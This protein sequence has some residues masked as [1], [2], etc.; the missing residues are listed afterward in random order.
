[1]N[2]ADAESLCKLACAP[3]NAEETTNIPK[4]DKG[5]ASKEEDESPKNEHVFLSSEL[6]NI[7]LSNNEEGCTSDEREFHHDSFPQRY[8]VSDFTTSSVSHF[9]DEEAT[10]LSYEAAH[11]KSNSSLHKDEPKDESGVEIP[12]KA[13]PLSNRERLLLRKQALKMKKR[14]VLAV[15][16]NNILTGVAKTIKTHF[17]KY[18]L[19]IVNVKGRA[20][21]TSVQEVIFELEQA[22]GSV[23]VS[24][25]PNKVI[26]Y[27]GWGEGEPPGSNLKDARKAS[28]GANEE[29]RVSLKLLEAVSLECGLSTSQLDQDIFD[30]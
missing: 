30:L 9:S 12:F 7:N 10:E 20:E 22:T 8:Q 14:P 13:A 1:M 18:P 2:E 26:L 5:I 21:G 16:R 28:V 19:A 11:S 25:E 6:S 29:G 4:N 23:L 3:W 24:R 15:G 27:R 17:K